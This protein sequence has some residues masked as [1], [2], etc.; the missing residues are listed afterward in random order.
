ML[1][2]TFTRLPTSNRTEVVYAFQVAGPRQCNCGNAYSTS[3]WRVA[4]GVIQKSSD[5]KISALLLHRDIV[6]LG[7]DHFGDRRAVFLLVSRILLLPEKATRDSAVYD[8]TMDWPCYAA[9]SASTTT[10]KQS[11]PPLDHCETS[12]AQ[13]HSFGNM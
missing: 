1:E 8:C 10:A 3:A 12:Y 9:Q 11:D 13:L 2:S 6:P 7:L 5:I 4:S